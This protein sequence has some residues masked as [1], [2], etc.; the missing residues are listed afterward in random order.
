L[1]LWRPGFGF[2]GGRRPR[3]GARIETFAII[4]QCMPVAQVAPRAGAWIE[5]ISGN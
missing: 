3:A 4:W 5:T 2:L 1:K